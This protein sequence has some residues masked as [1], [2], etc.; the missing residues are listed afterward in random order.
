MK[1]ILFILVSLSVFS[2]SSFAQ[3]PKAVYAQLGGPGLIVSANF[4]TRLSSKDDGFGLRAGIGGMGIE[5]VGIYTLPLGVNYLLGKDGKNYFEVGAGYTL[6]FGGSVVDSDFA[7]ASLGNLTIG[8]RRAPQDG[9]F[10]FK[11]ELTPLFRSE[12]FMPY[13]GGL[14]FGYK[15]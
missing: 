14:G 11:A 9:G 6:L 3:A 1:K 15:F 7:S 2:F 13:F 8:Y 5:G 12:F 10:F 4:D